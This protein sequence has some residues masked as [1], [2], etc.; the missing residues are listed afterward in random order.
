MAANRPLRIV[1]IDD[2]ADSTDTLAM[3]LEGAGYEVIR[4]YDGRDG[5]ERVC[6][7]RPDVILLDLAMP[8]LDGYQVARQIRARDACKGALLVAVTGYGDD[9]HRRL[10][11]EAG[12]DHYLVKPV[13]FMVLRELLEARRNGKA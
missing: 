5:I 2:N 3:V 7:C 6:A 8:E 11:R 12:F 1:A 9:M 4:A 10:A 13:D